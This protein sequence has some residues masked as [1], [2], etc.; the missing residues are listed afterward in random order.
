MQDALPPLSDAASC[1]AEA[2]QWAYEIYC[3]TRMQLAALPQPLLEQVLGCVKGGS[4]A[5]MLGPLRALRPVN[6][7]RGY[8]ADVAMALRA[9]NFEFTPE[10]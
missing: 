10:E 9:L 3:T 6:G 2:R 7:G 4:T 5:D 8:D 1:E